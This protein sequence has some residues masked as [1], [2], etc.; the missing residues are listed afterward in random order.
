MMSSYN[1]DVRK[2][3]SKSLGDTLLTQKK[4][5]SSLAQVFFLYSITSEIIKFQLYNKI[6][7][8]IKNYR[9]QKVVLN[10]QVEACLLKMY[11][12]IYF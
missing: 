9:C 10:H 1:K 12:A 8:I 7:F 3:R 5:K 11:I 6:Y 2:R 4:I